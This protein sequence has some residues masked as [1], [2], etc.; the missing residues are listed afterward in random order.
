VKDFFGSH[1]L[2]INIQLANSPV[3]G[4]SP[5]PA[6]RN[7]RPAVINADIQIPVIRHIAIV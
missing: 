6:F 5:F 3:N 4:F 2:V 7:R 1:C